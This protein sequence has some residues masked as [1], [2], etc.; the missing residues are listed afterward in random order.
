MDYI[1]N[2]IFT[3]WI[4][5]II[6]NRKAVTGVGIIFVFIFLAVFGPFITQDPTAFLSTPLSPPS[7]EYWLVSPLALWLS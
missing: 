7:W 4:T 6:Q 5:G 1:H 2:S 3:R